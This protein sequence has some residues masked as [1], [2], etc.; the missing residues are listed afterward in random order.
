MIGVWTSGFYF[1]K[2]YIF[3]KNKKCYIYNLK[4]NKDGY[5]IHL[6]ASKKYIS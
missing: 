4:K 2:F 5:Q 1:I 3:L 6:P